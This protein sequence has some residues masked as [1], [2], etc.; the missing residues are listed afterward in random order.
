MSDFPVERTR[1]GDQF[2]IPGTEK[3]A[4][5]KP[6]KPRWTGPME[7]DGSGQA[8]LPGAERISD[9]VLAERRW[10]DKARPKRGQKAPGGPLF[11]STAPDQ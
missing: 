8:V 9:K 1:A 10:A 6:R 2:I 11:R 5:A 7:A 4:Q 3:P